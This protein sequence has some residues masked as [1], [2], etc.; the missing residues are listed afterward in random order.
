ML[1]LRIIKTFE[2]ITEVLVTQNNFTNI[3]VSAS[4][5]TLRGERVGII[6]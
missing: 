1:F 5:I 4:D 2:A 3:T 6:Y